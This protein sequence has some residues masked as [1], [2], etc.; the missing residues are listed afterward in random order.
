MKK[1]LAFDILTLLVLQFIFFYGLEAG[2]HW[3]N[4]QYFQVPVFLGWFNVQMLLLT[5]GAI[6]L[7]FFVLGV[8]GS[9]LAW[10]GVRRP[11]KDDIHTIFYFFAFSFPVA[12]AGRLLVP[13]FDLWYARGAG[14]LTW[15]GVGAFAVTLYFSVLKEE[16]LQRLMQRMLMERFSNLS[17]AVVMALSFSFAHYFTPVR[18]GVASVISIALVACLL[19]LLYLRTRNILTTLLF[20]Y[21]FNL[22]ITLQI[23]LHAGGDAVG[24]WL[25]WGIWGAL[26]F[27]TA[28]PAWEKIRQTL[29]FARSDI[30]LSNAVFLLF[31]GLVLPLLYTF[32]LK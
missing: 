17:V 13:D 15:A 30:Q 29:T 22:I 25:L 14:L 9:T 27:S 5:L 26:F 4:T 8:R 19:A 28:K 23:S 16:A 11:S 18:F 10:L 3:L 2:Y 31:F 24:E 32:L 21:F 1:S 7:L 6:A 12:I 20:H